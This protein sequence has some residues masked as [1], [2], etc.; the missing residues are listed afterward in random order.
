MSV[1]PASD[2]WDP[3]VALPVGTVTG[4]VLKN[5]VRQYLGVPYAE[6]PVGGSRAAAFEAPQALKMLRPEMRAGTKEPNKPYGGGMP[7]LSLLL[8]PGCTCCV[9]CCFGC[10]NTSENTDGGGKDVGLDVLRVSIWAPPP[11]SG[12]EAADS[13]VS[14]GDGVPVMVFLH[15]GAVQA[16]RASS[17]P[18]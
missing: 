4:K 17:T 8:C 9:A 5:G 3:S 1:K 11:K 2:A 6:P 16:R 14:S 10:R 15:G 13:G 12:D 7:E 18:A